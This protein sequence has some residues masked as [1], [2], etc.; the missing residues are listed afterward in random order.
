MKHFF[1]LFIASVFVLSTTAG[2]QAQSPRMR[3]YGI[4]T[5][6]MQP[7]PL[8]AITDVKGVSVGHVTL[9]EGDSIR[10][11]V[12]AIIPHPGNIFREKVPAAFWA[13]N[14]YGKLAGSTQIKELG[15]IETPVILTNTL[16][17]SAGIDGLVTYTLQQPGNGDVQSVNAVVGETNDGG[18]ND[19][20]GRHVKPEHVLKALKNA[21]S[22][23][24]AEGNVGAGTGTVCFGFKGGIGTASR[25]L[26]KSL[27]GYTVGV[28]VQT[29]FGGVLQ[30]AGV[31][32][33]ERLGRYSYKNQIEDQ[34]G[35]TRPGQSAPEQ[36][37]IHQKKAQVTDSAPDGSCMIV[38]I[39]DAPMNE[40][41]L[42]RMA[43]RGMMGLARTGGIASN[44]SGDYVLALSVAPENLIK[45]YA[46][47]TQPYS[48]T[49]S[50]TYLHNNECSPLFLAAIEAVEEAILNALFAAETMTGKDGYTVEAL[51]V[52]K[53]VKLF[54]LVT[55]IE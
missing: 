10:T 20:R 52:E 46:S 14:G 19:I 33:G 8:N 39:T 49:W 51:P 4:R 26:P 55:D 1:S 42:E 41:N 37:T 32:V 5:G 54:P 35:R 36:Q 16:S 28:L 44:G 12:T 27:G 34:S 15:N 29:N 31:N 53:V 45:E 13:G 47:A 11:G 30:I 3:D 2:I 50:P 48:P 23:P 17:V 21:V 7:G 38:I 18:L 40:R 24:V 43:K 6:V 22:G 25:I 9:V